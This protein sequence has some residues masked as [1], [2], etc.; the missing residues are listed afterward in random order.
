MDSSSLKN[1]NSDEINN[2]EEEDDPNLR[3]SRSV[4]VE[5]FHRQRRIDGTLPFS[6]QI[7]TMQHIILTNGHDGRCIQSD[8]TVDADLN[9]GGVWKEIIHTGIGQIPTIGACV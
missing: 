5:P 3:D 6:E 9:Q 7:L 8:N 4:H 1:I 2:I